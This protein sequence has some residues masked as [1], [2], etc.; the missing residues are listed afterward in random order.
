MS[1]AR[2]STKRDG[3]ERSQKNPE[4]DN[5]ISELKNSLKGFNSNQSSSISKLEDRSFQITESEG[6]EEKNEGK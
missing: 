1:K 2:I 6:Q 3:V 5:K 4:G